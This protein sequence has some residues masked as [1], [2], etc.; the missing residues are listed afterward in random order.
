MFSLIF[1]ILL[2]FTLFGRFM[3]NFS[4][5]YFASRFRFG[6]KMFKL[7]FTPIIHDSNVTFTFQLMYIYWIR[8]LIL[9]SLRSHLVAIR[10]KWRICLFNGFVIESFGRLL[11][12]MSLNEIRLVDVFGLYCCEWCDHIWNESV[13]CN[14][15]MLIL[16]VH[17]YYVLH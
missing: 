10:K 13:M 1:R 8:F 16:E 5:Y 12:E 15:Q 17:V 7:K 14:I 4:I 9:N 6:K 11:F 2:S 3:I